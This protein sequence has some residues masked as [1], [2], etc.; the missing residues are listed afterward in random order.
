M[1]VRSDNQDEGVLTSR[2]QICSPK[3]SPL[4]NLI[5]LSNTNLFIP[6]VK[7]VPIVC[8]TVLLKLRSLKLSKQCH[9]ASY[10]TIHSTSCMSLFSLVTK[11]YTQAF[12]LLIRSAAGLT[13]KQA[14]SCWSFSPLYTK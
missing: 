6:A 3:H 7:C 13:G 10:L 11:I 8:S 4:F 14:F 1:V 12:N 9:Q 5:K 2:N